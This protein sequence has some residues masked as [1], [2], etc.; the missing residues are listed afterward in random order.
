MSQIEIERLLGRLITDANF[1]V[2]A[3]KSLEHAVSKEGF[4]LSKEE[5][6]LLY[7]SDF[8]QFGLV[9]ATLNDSIR[10]T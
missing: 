9:A 3:A 8:S 5:L 2:R 1:R 6:T 7:G 10:R 4:A